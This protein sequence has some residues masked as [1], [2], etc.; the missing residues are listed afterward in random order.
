MITNLST[1]RIWV[2]SRRR[3]FVRVLPTRWRRKPAGI[4]VE[5]NYITITLY[6]LVF[7]AELIAVSVCC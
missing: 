7:V 3:A 2:I 6:M 1:K 4:D 5:R